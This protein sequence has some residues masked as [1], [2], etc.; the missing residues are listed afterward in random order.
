MQNLPT[1]ALHSSNGKYQASNLYL[2]HKMNLMARHAVQGL[3]VEVAFDANKC[4]YPFAMCDPQSCNASMG[5]GSLYRPNAR[6]ET[7]Q[8]NALKG[9][10]CLN[11]QS[12]I[13]SVNLFG[14]RCHAMS[15]IAFECSATAGDVDH[16]STAI[17]S[18]LSDATLGNLIIT[19]NYILVYHQPTTTTGFNLDA[20]I[21][22]WKVLILNYS[23]IL[24]IYLLCIYRAI[25][26][27]RL[28]RNS[29]LYITNV[30]SST[31]IGGGT[32]DFSF[33]ELQSYF[34]QH[35]V[36][37]VKARFKYH[38]YIPHSVYIRNNWS[39]EIY[40]CN[41]PF[42]V[43]THK[44]TIPKLRQIAA[45]HGIS[46]G[47]KVH[48]AQI[49]EWIFKHECK[50]C[51]QHV[52]LFA[53]ID[54]TAKG[55]TKR[56]TNQKAVQKYRDAYEMSQLSSVFRSQ[57]NVGELHKLA[58]STYVKR[59]RARKGHSC[60]LE[61][62][63]H[64]RRYQARQKERYKLLNIKPELKHRIKHTLES[65]RKEEHSEFP[66]PRIGI[67]LL[68]T[69]V[70]ESCKAMTTEKISEAGC[71]VC[72]RLT[73]IQQLLKLTEVDI[74]FDIL[75]RH[76]VTRK[77]RLDSDHSV[78]DIEGAVL[79]QELDSICDSC[80]KSMVNHKVPL[81]ALANGNWL[82][83]VPKQLSDLSFA[84]QLLIAKI[85]HNCCVVR[86]SSGMRKMRAN[87]VSFANPIP[88]VY[89]ILP[90]PREDLDEVL[91][92]IYTG[93]CQP[94]EKDF[95]RTPFLVRR[96]KVKNALEWLKLN[97]RD[98][99]D[100]QISL[101]NLNQY[102]DNSIPVLVD[103]RKSFSNKNPESTAV[104]DPDEEDG[105]E[106]GMC[107]FVVHGLTGDE[108]TEKSIQ[109]LKAIALNHLTNDGKVLAIGH[110]PNPE[111]IYHNPQLFPKMMPWLFPYGLGGIGNA[112]Q[113]GRISDIA[114]KR[115]L[116]MYY[117]KRFQMDPHFPLIA[118]NHEQIKQATSA[119]YLLA[120]KAKFEHITK[121][122]LSID[123]S[124]MDW[125]TKRMENGEKVKPETDEEKQCFRLIKDL[126]HV[127]GHVK[128]SAT[129]KK[130]MRNELWSLMSFKGAPSW[131]ITF[132]PA[133]NKH[134]ICLY[135]ADMQESFDPLLRR[136]ND[137]RYHLIARNPVSGARFFHFMCEL[138]I[139]NVLGVG[140][141]RPGIYGATSA[142]YGTVEQQGRLTL[143]LH[144]LLWIVGS[145]S[146]QEIRNRIMDP[147]SDFQ[148]KMIEYLESVHVGEFLTGSM[149]DVKEN[150]NTDMRR[151]NYWDPTETLPNPPP[152]LCNINNHTGTTCSCL[153]EWHNEFEHT[154]DDLIFRSNVHSCRKPSSNKKE[155]NK[156]QR[157]TCQNK[158]GNCKARFPRS[159]VNQT[160]VDPKTGALN[161]KKKE[162]W[163]NT[164]TP[165][166]TFI[167]RC[168]SDVTSLL[169][170]TAIKAVVAYVSDYITKNGLNTYSIFEAIKGILDRHSEIL[171]GTTERKEKARR[172]I[173]KIV[174]TLTS[175][176]EIGGPMASLYL[177]GNPDHYTS[178]QFVSFY[179]KNYVREAMKPWQTFDT[180]EV[181][182][183]P[184]KVVL[185]KCEDKYVGVSSVHDYIHR[186]KE[187]ENVPLYEW[188][189]SAKRIRKGTAT[190]EKDHP[191]SSYINNPAGQENDGLFMRLIAI[192]SISVCE[193]NELEGPT[194]DSGV[195]HSTDG[196]DEPVVDSDFDYF[197]GTDH[198]QGPSAFQNDK[199]FEFSIDHPLFSTHLVRFDPTR[200]NIVPNFIGGSL[201]RRDRGDREY[202]CATM[203]VLFKPWRNGRCLKSEMNSWHDEFISYNFT[204]RQRDLMD[205]FNLRYECNDARD[206]YSAQLKI[207]N[208]SN[209]ESPIWML[210][211]DEGENVT[212]TED[213]EHILQD[214]CSDDGNSSGEDESEVN[215]Y[216][217]LNRYGKI[218]MAQMDA[219]ANSVK[220]AG[221]LD[222]SPDGLHH[223]ST[224]PVKPQMELPGSRWKA[225][226]EDK[227]NEILAIRNSN[228][229]AASTRTRSKNTFHPDPNE[230][231][232]QI[233][234][235]LY[236]SRNFKCDS[237]KVQV[238]LEQTIKDFALN[239][240]QDR[241]FRIV[242]N[243]AASVGSEQ[244]KMYL[245]GMGGTGKSQVIKSLKRYFELRGQAHRFMILGPTGTSAALLGGSTYHSVL[246]VNI[247]G[248]G[249][250]N[251][252]QVRAKLEGVDYI[253]ID[254]V[255]MISCHQLYTISARLAK[256]LGERQL[257]FG[258]MNMI[259][260]GDFAQLPPVGGSSLYSGNVGTNIDSALHI[261]G[262]ESAI[263]KALWHQVTTVVILREN[264]RQKKQTDDDTRLRTALSNMR[265]AACTNEDINFLNTRIAGRGPNRP[266]ISSKN[267]RNVAI[268]CGVHT[269][270]DAINQLGCGR[271][272]SDTGQELTHFY[273]IDKWGK[274]KPNSGRKSQKTANSVIHNSNEINPGDQNEIWKLH[275]GRT[276]HLPGKLSLCIGMPVIIKHNYATELC[277]TNGQEGF[278]VGWQATKDT[279][280]KLALDTLFV[281]LDNPP[282]TVQID[283]LI[284]N[285]VPIVKVTQKI[286]CQ[287]L[288]G[289]T[290]SVER[291]QVA[292][293]PNFAM[294]AH[295]SQGKTRPFNVVHLNSCRDHMAY[296]T[297]L[298][299]S[300]SASG[301]II[302]QGFDHNVITSKC[303]GYLRQE[304]RDQEIL[305]EITKLRYNGTLPK[306]VD[307]HLR[308]TLI[309]Q[310]R[311]QRGLTYV[312]EQADAALRWSSEKDFPLVEATTESPW[313]LI[314]KATTNPKPNT[315]D[316]KFK[317]LK[318]VHP[319]S[320]NSKR[321][322]E[323]DVVTAKRQ[324]VHVTRNVNQLPISPLGLIWDGA[325]YSCSYDALFVILYD[326][327]TLDH[328]KWT[329]RFTNMNTKYTHDLNTAFE[330]ITRGQ[331]NFELA[332]DRIRDCL[333]HQKPNVFPMG[334]FGASVG[335]L[336][337][338]IFGPGKPLIDH[339]HTCTACPYRS[340]PVD[341]RIS[342]VSAVRLGFAGTVTD[343]L[344]RNRPTDTRCPRCNAAL[345]RTIRYRELPDV[346]LF[347]LYNPFDVNIVQRVQLD[348][349]TDVYNLSLRGLIYLGDFHFTA[350]IISPEA[351]VWYHDGRT[352]RKTCTYEGKFHSMSND[353]VRICYGKELKYFLYAK[354]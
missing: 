92:I 347:E 90:P 193:N 110:A 235:R 1:S 63:E 197:G 88:K 323:E 289:L 231:N 264:M 215:R 345:T 266:K 107:P 262:Q 36:K 274:D 58:Q 320:A 118:F 252:L 173:T 83:K 130:Y 31:C 48:G 247:S 305:D 287:F 324:K 319:L 195:E 285:V 125:L 275:P 96:N 157:P 271:F 229:Q 81:M 192:D 10:K 43:V 115:S 333:H 168:N 19:G 108:Y 311:Q 9:V 11:C 334:R 281:K 255:S 155:P 100:L 59:Y 112:L 256:A 276:G 213:A 234:N 49:R 34:L 336:T 290:E 219:A 238:I 223:I 196:M 171:G 267:F 212:D 37:Y 86:V 91:A 127:G 269:Q 160:E 71:A 203:L 143:H 210:P 351:D 296:Y 53:K 133:D 26:I 60:K 47:T 259:F 183:R 204:S 113:H 70:T 230:N 352:T 25:T 135:Y 117:D 201:P 217:E 272:A 295:A 39:D 66:P 327:W 335:D 122:L 257:P 315:T 233:V 165:A 140:E 226:T 154:V 27:Q 220:N 216:S 18:T 245:G 67:G 286:V 103:Y 147:T 75:I 187:H 167:I 253:F 22:P 350:R 208:S 42:N 149:S 261:R 314:T 134:P 348:T 153:A 180:M 132:A 114:R 12:C 123:P 251:I 169:S 69:I 240:E 353:E 218:L 294:T 249:N 95:Q 175:K 46:V 76:G 346:I 303:S 164:L 163:I 102:P 85:R 40:A 138:F 84:E 178:H 258:G 148:T 33:E 241:A 292:V 214:D 211:G 199:N 21:D 126:D 225:L 309:R 227:K 228:I 161:M 77:E 41:T 300:A 20:C 343:W 109:A 30:S 337:N 344:A 7:C 322:H 151:S 176:M 145:L 61:N 23:A 298:S 137:T 16:L 321:K 338:E 202:Y 293:Q 17:T 32:S 172:L 304:F 3:S 297:A 141:N 330:S 318:E 55:R 207:K 119:G 209:S 38:D 310:Y 184:E 306:D 332:R 312:P 89:N 182:E 45:C 111:S 5:I 54:D 72:G 174:N 301:T 307:G 106:S 326:L 4:R 121:R 222:E 185:Q 189:Q 237:N 331:A 14:L 270:K 243:H 282:Q 279:S 124:T 206:D 308:N 62:L 152:P 139:K 13:F 8:C 191:K 236:I 268:I 158:D 186:P 29:H 341:S 313:Q 260:A 354:D 104:N 302:V 232:A 317:L 177:L 265:Y 329:E 78:E 105:T 349:G 162:A 150:I 239:V 221:W 73:P 250:D 291:R 93:P 200:Y 188:V 136:D 56:D 263:G 198:D 181:D 190:Q 316:D 99:H 342:S 64:V 51:V 116:L 284:E 166:L 280:G 120:N 24:C 156:T 2:L 6:V 254:E 325:N 129:T 170:G 57:L 82:G 74:D 242:A 194:A 131:F 299:R 288:N 80:R 283:G 159:V 273:S 340:P 79:E 35:D 278:V 68:H 65:V 52:T 87:A 205:N 101:D 44:L 339:R 277:I 50:N 97:H 146:P 94:T 28:K 98:Y 144:L 328:A 142:Y 224:T 179:W 246:K 244:L 128:G 15:C 248:S